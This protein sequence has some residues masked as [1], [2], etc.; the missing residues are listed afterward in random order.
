[1]VTQGVVHVMLYLVGGG[2]HM[3]IHGVVHVV[4]RRGWLHME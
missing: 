3:V 2:L 4:S 1:M